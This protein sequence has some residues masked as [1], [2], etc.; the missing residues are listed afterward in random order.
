MSVTTKFDV[1]D[2]AYLAT[3]ARQGNLSAV[4]VVRVETDT[5][6]S[7]SST[8]IYQVNGVDSFHSSSYYEYDLKTLLEAKDIAEEYLSAEITKL[9]SQLAR[10]RGTFKP[11][12]TTVTIT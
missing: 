5:V 12:S 4:M 9:Q 6:S 11:F 8:N 1:G 2:I 3:E 7:G 10:V